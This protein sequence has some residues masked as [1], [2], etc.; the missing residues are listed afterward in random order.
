MVVVASINLEWP[1]FLSHGFSA[2]G[3]LFS[4]SGTSTGA[5]VTAV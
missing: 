5:A 3:W 4:V 1:A 2:L